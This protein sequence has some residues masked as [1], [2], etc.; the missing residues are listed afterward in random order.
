MVNDIKYM[1]E[2]LRRHKVAVSE[3]KLSEG[4]ILHL[5]DFK[6]DI[7]EGTLYKDKNNNCK[8][9][10]LVNIPIKSSDNYNTISYE[11]VRIFLKYNC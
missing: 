9:L 10:N 3:S 7:Y 1:S 6:I 8:I 2:W 4:F 5:L 11:D